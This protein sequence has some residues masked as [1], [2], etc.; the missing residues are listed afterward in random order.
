MLFRSQLH[1][2]GG[3]TSIGFGMD[4]VRSLPDA[5]ARAI[6]MHLEEEERKAEGGTTA[7]SIDEH[8]STPTQ[9]NGGSAPLASFGEVQQQH[10][11]V[12]GNLCP[13]CG[14]NTLVYAEG[15]KKCMACGHSEC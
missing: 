12:I 5:V 15:C 2:I 3:S 9:A 8:V 4:R 14:C 13:Q 10:Y 6:S 11:A 1:S 7:A